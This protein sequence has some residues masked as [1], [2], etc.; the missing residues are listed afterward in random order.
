MTLR[1]AFVPEQGIALF[2]DVD[3]TLLE[4]AALPDGV[5]VPAALRNTLQLAAQREDGALALLSGR[6][7]EALDRLFA[8]SVFAAAGLHGFERRDGRGSFSCT[9]FDA[10]ALPPIRSALQDWVQ[11][12][13]GLL[14]EDKGVALA[15]HYRNAPQLQEQ[16]YRIMHEAATALGPCFHLLAGKCAVELAPAHCSVRAAIE[17][18]MGEPPFAGRTPV[19]VSDDSTDEEAFE[20]VNALCGHS[21]RVGAPEPSVE[22][23]AAGYRFASVAGVVAWLRER[24]THPMRPRR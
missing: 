11:R 6:S 10:S 13:R 21:I 16:A 20:V 17:A 9:P 4:I 22:Q 23:S 12:H 15:L 24:N 18:F 7:I 19:F 1:A 2:L 14:L 3:G 8:P 5:R